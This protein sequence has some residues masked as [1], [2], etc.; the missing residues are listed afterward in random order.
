MQSSDSQAEHIRP[1]RKQG[2]T[3]QP[4]TTNCATSPKLHDF[5]SRDPATRKS[6]DCR[7]Q[8]GWNKR[9]AVPASGCSLAVRCRNG[10]LLVPADKNPRPQSCQHLSTT[11]AFR[12][13]LAVAALLFLIWLSPALAE[14]KVVL[15]LEGSTSQVTLGGTIMDYTGSAL[16]ILLRSGGTP[17]SY[18]AAQV[19]QVRTSQGEAHQQG[20]KLFAEK[21]IGEASVAFQRAMAIEKRTWVRRE[22]LALRIRCA[23]WMSD[24]SAAA[25][26]FLSLVNSD[27][28][29]RHFKLIPLRW[30]PTRLDAGTKNNAGVWLSAENEVA[31]LIGASLLLNDQRY[32]EAAESELRL[33]AASSDPRVRY[34][35]RAQAWRPQLRATDISHLILARWAAQIKTMPEELRGGPYYLLGRGHM[36]R[37]E[38]ELAATAFLWI[39]LVYD[40]DH[41]LAARACLEAADALAAIGQTD[42]AT[43]LFREVQQDYADTTFAQEAAALLKRMSARGSKR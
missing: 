15:Q 20:L 8:V 17:K 13:E 9:N 6:R 29:T 4:A 24:Y 37:R 7:N 27:P 1:K 19:I 12:Q 35:A 32:G 34:L 30:T 40:F 25:T 39:P 10:A 21:H 3:V 2:L 33:L 14:D 41:Q 22:I 16:S 42:E 43:T 5:P 38:N 11:H 36:L 23:L 31:R 28:E 18:P 26:Q